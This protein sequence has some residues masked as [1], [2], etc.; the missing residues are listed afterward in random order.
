MDR[1]AK[2]LKRGLTPFQWRIYE[3]LFKESYFDINMLP[4]IPGSLLYG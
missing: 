2:N 3:A 4:F 1:I